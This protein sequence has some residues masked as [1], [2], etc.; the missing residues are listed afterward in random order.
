VV[1][2]CPFG[3]QMQR[4]IADAISSVPALSQYVKVKYI[5]SVSGDGKTITAMHGEE[6]AK[7]NLRQICIREEQP[8]KYW[9]YLAC[10]M[11]AGDASGCQTT[12]GVNSSTLNSCI[13]NPGKGVAYAQE[14]FEASS[15]YDVSGSPTLALNGSIVSEFDYGGRTSNAV[16]SVVC[17]GFNSPAGFC[18]GADL[19]T[20][21]VATGFS[22][23]YE[24]Q[25]G[26]A[27]N[28]ASCN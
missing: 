16:R 11:K 18:S 2:M 21:T 10:Y 22:P 27:N 9:G 26:S 19:N 8:A 5:G 15:N 20:A 6:E 13:S 3:L 17:A 7:E 14:D 28:S 24:A 4:M 1:S 12:A 25:G 23:S